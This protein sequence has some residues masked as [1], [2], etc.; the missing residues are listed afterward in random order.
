MARLSQEKIN[1]IRQSVDIVDVIGQYLSLEKRGRNYLAIC[2][3]H[4]DNNPSMSVSPDR[5]IF[6]CFVCHTGG[7]VFTFL[8]KYLKISYIEAI[9]KVAEMGHIDLSDYHLDYEKKPVKQENVALY[10]MYQEAQKI[11]S[12]YLNTKLGLEAKTYLLKRHFNEELIK[13]FQIG[14]A[15]INSVLY[16]SFSKLGFQEIDMVKSGL[17]IE[18]KQHFDRFNDR[19]M[20]PLHNQ[21]GEVVGF[22]G[23]IYKP[24]QHDSKYINSPESDI[25]HKGDTL[26]H[27]HKCR[28]AVKKAGFVYLLEGFM[29]VIAMYKAGIENTVAI[30]G[31]ALTNGHIQAL[32]RLTSTV[33]LCLDGDQAG[34]AAMS[35]AINLLNEAGLSVKIIILPDGKDPDEIFESDGEN[36]LKE[37][38]KKTLKPIEFQM[39]FEYQF[40]DNQNYDDRKQYLEKICLAIA[41]LKDEVDRDYYIHQLAQKSGFS[42]DIVQQK[43]NGLKLKSYEDVPVH[44]EVKKVIKLVDKYKEAEHDLLFYMLMSKE[45]ASKYEAKAGFMYNDQYRVIASYIIDYYRRHNQLIIADFINGISKDDLIQTVIEISESALPLPYEEKAIDDYIHT[46]ALNARKMKKEQL[47]EQ[48]HYVL[49][50]IQKSEILNEIVKLEYEKESI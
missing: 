20:F 40:V 3:F 26:Y 10:Q 49:D 34:Q 15:P 8:Q 4:D 38:L 47:L 48:F 11:Y 44:R 37:V 25:F 7:N 43:V 1:E 36:G 30:M 45:V 19:I 31:T 22:S 6:M 28:E 16:Q 32:R 29:D 2:P 24:T 27:Y 41:Q 50:P 12:Y 33:Y 21:Q 9:K 23:R 46:I 17:V 18:S 13:E 14:Y 42:F 35:K 5:Q 39:E